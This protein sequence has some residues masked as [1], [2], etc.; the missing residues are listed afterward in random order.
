MNSPRQNGQAAM[1][2]TRLNLDTDEDADGARY[3]HT[4]MGRLPSVTTILRATEEDQPVLNA[5]R[6]RVGPVRAA[7][8]AAQAR[9]RGIA[10]H[11]E[12]EA[13]FQAG[14]PAISGSAYLESVRPFLNRLGEIG[15][16]EGAVWHPLGF[17]G[18]VDC[19]ALVDGVLSIID[20]KT[21][22]S[23][24]HPDWVIDQHLQVAAYRAAVEKHY[25]VRIPRGFVVFALASEDAQVFET[26]DLDGAFSAFAERFEMFQGSVT[27][28]S[29]RESAE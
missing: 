10:F 25:R 13:Y 15:L 27:A 28:L 21:A 29:Q 3:Y 17:A 4:P 2:L 8:I 26:L 7:I 11:E 14:R 6:S 16:V 20:W 18:C 23:P 12:M 1:T 9:E 19:V 5:W 24:K 22:S